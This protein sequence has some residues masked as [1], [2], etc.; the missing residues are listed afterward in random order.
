MLRHVAPLSFFT[1]ADVVI[2]RGRISFLES[3]IAP[4]PLL[5]SADGVIVRFHIL[6]CLGSLL[7]HP[8]ATPAGLTPSSHKR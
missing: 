1:S 2:E 4:F 8:I 6:F 5:T 7:A 3:L